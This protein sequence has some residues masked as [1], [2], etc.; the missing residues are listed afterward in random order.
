MEITVDLKL[1]RFIR[2]AS[3]RQLVDLCLFY[4]TKYPTDATEFM[5]EA[6]EPGVDITPKDVPTLPRTIFI[7]N[8]VMAELQAEY[9]RT[10]SADNVAVIRQLRTLFNIGL[11][12]ALDTV[13]WLAANNHLKME[14][15]Y[16][17]PPSVAPAWRA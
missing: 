5:S 14:A 16:G 10:N 12:E 15:G 11:K 13:R 9:S 1:V 4:I 7:P 17:A 6:D 2:E 3:E 8:S